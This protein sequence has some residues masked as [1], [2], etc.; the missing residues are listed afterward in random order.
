MDLGST[1][2][3]ASH[4]AISFV[5]IF[6]FLTSPNQMFFSLS[7]LNPLPLSNGSGCRSPR[8]SPR[9][10]TTRAS[11]CYRR[12]KSRFW[13]NFLRAQ[14]KAE[15]HPKAG[16]VLQ[17]LHGRLLHH[18]QLH[19]LAL[20]VGRRGLLRGARGSRK[21]ELVPILKAPQKHRSQIYFSK[22]DEVY[23]GHRQDMRRSG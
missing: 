5:L 15:T 3:K 21:Q 16:K 14:G 11:K 20:V 4:L 10:P 9:R 1:E 2:R 23:F 8:K 17:L 19:L 7:S 22:H 6:S 12:Y 18:L 13:W